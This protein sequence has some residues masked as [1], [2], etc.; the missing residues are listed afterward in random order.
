MICDMAETYHIFD[1]RGLPVQTLAT[2][3]Q[4]L[5]DGSRVKMELSGMKVDTRTLLIA[6]AVDDLN[7]LAWA[8]TQDGQKG[9]N[10]PKS[11]VNSLLGTDENT[12]NQD[13]MVFDSPEA[14][15]K[16]WKKVFP[17]KED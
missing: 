10:R 1:I 14:F 7:F 8:Q 15:N 4:G 11:I 9:R 12:P 3:V 6:A 17:G 16:M 13:V 5:R 2:L